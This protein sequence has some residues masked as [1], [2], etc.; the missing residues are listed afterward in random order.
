GRHLA[1][2]YGGD[3]AIDAGGDDHVDCGPGSVDEG[4]VDVGRTGH[5]APAALAAVGVEEE[6][7]AGRTGV[8]RE[9]VGGGQRT[10]VGVALGTGRG[11]RG[12]GVTGVAA[13]AGGGRAAD[14]E[15]RTQEGRV[16]GR[17]LGRGR[18]GVA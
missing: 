6:V 17:H 15:G 16:G 5:A 10:G 2:A 3:A 11:G 18:S 12:T 13:V 14:R 1:A 9:G 8:A 4:D 7:V